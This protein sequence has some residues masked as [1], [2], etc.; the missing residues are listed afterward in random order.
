MGYIVQ[1]SP[2]TEWVVGLGR[3]G[4]V[5]GGMTD[6]SAEIPFQSF[7]QVWH[8]QGCLVVDVVHPAFPLPTTA[9]PTLQGVLKV[10]F[11]EAAVAFDMPEPCEFQSLDS[12]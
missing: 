10:G 8:G 4:G 5:G 12:C 3:P 2:F 9:S 1:F 11:G 6:D 7:L